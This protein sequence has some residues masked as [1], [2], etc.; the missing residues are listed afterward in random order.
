[1]LE[2]ASWH[3]TALFLGERPA[4]ACDH[5][6]TVVQACASSC[7]PIT[8]QQ[9]ALHSIPEPRPTMRWIRFLPHPALT[10]LHHTLADRLGLQP[11]PFKP[12]WPHI[13]LARS[14]RGGTRALEDEGM[15]L[16][17][18]LRL[19][20][21]SLYRSDVSGTGR[22]HRPMDTWSF[23]GTGPADPEVAV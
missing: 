11:S 10:S 1:M 5:L 12:Y 18:T 7:A 4:S 9:G 3:V 23:T 17:P 21:L 15:L 6:F 19:T 13:T 16:L 22:I 8:L 2:Q 20:S 14:P